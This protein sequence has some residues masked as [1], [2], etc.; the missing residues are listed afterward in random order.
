MAFIAALFG[1]GKKSESAPAPQ[2]LP[3]PPAVEDSS[4]KAEENAKKK[5]ATVAAGSKSI[6]SSPLG[7][8]GEAQVAKAGLKEKLGQ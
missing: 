2:P 7:I 4:A 8:A 5:R 1:G 3:T 6:Y